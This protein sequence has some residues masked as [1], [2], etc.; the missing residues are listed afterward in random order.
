MNGKAIRAGL[1]KQYE[2]KRPQDVRYLF[3]LWL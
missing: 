2:N 3:P 1:A